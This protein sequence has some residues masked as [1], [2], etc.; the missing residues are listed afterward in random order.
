MHVKSRRDLCA[1]KHV[2]DMQV[3]NLHCRI[4]QVSSFLVECADAPAMSFLVRSCSQRFR[5]VIDTSIAILS[6]IA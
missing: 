5:R 6:I 3:G 1:Y 2:E 4:R